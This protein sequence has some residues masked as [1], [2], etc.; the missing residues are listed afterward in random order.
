[1]N[2]TFRNSKVPVTYIYRISALLYFFFFKFED[3]DV[4]TVKAVSVGRNTACCKY[5]TC[6]LSEE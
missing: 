1:M 6:N 2:I 5:V 3:M 4:T